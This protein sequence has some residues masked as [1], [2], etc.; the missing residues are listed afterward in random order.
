MGVLKMMLEA[1]VT[2]G[3][4]TSALK[5]EAEHTMNLD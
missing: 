5:K 1:E 2:T 3:R 4:E